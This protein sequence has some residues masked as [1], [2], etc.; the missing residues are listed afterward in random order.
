MKKIIFVGFYDDQLDELIGLLEGNTEA[1][2][3]LAYLKEVFDNARK[4]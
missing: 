3:I 1:G 2:D 4:D